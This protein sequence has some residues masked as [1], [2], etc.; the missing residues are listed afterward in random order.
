MGSLMKIEPTYKLRGYE[1]D[2]T[3]R[4]LTQFGTIRCRFYRQY[5]RILKEADVITDLFRSVHQRFLA[6]IDHLDYY[7]SYKTSRER[8]YIQ[9]GEYIP[10]R[11]YEDLDTSESEFLDAILREIQKLKPEIYKSLIREK[12]FNL[13]TWVIG[14]GTW[15][16]MRNIK[17][18][19]ENIKVLQ[20]QNILQEKQY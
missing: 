5:L 16:N 20:D 11:Q 6:A 9:E 10:K 12:R 15:S 18:I 4:E 3:Q 14:W 2:C 19:K 13:M 8:R 7:P 17:K 1:W